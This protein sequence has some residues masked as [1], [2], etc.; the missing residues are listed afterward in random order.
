MGIKE[1][2]ECVLRV[3]FA[4][5]TAEEIQFESLRRRLPFVMTI[6]ICWGASQD[7]ELHDKSMT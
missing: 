3:W 5:K 1:E 4:W 2:K 7:D 6:L